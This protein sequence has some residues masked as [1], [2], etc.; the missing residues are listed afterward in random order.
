MHSAASGSSPNA[1]SIAA[2]AISPADDDVTMSNHASH[3]SIVAVTAARG[4]SQRTLWSPAQAVAANAAASA[5]SKPTHAR[6]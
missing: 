5:M 3:R 4:A 6:S 1:A 2:S